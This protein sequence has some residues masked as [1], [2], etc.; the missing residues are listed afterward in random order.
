MLQQGSKD[1]GTCDVDGLVDSLEKD[2]AAHVDSVCVNAVELVL[3]T[4]WKAL[5]GDRECLFV[6]LPI[7]RTGVWRI[8]LQ[9]L[10]RSTFIAPSAR[11]FLT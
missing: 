4:D 3:V 8:C 6:M 7:L 5:C 10:F 9:A 11:L 1:D 2:G